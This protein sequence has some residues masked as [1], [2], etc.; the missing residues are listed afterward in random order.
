MKQRNF[1]TCNDDGYAFGASDQG[2][3]RFNL[4]RERRQRQICRLAYM[5][6]KRR[7]F[8]PGNELRDWLEAEREVDEA[9]RPLR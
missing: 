4:L 7:G 6:A 3:R 1:P 2:E 8:R 5:K 9:S